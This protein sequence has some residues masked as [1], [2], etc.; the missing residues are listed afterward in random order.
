MNPLDTVFSRRPV[1]LHPN[2]NRDPGPRRHGWARRWLCV[3]LLA[4][5][6]AMAVCTVATIDQKTVVTATVVL[7][8]SEHCEATVPAFPAPFTCDTELIGTRSG[9]SDSYHLYA[10]NMPDTAECITRDNYTYCYADGDPPPSEIAFQCVVEIHRAL[11]DLLPATAQSSCGCATLK[12][13]PHPAK[14]S[15]G[16]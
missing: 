13:A 1:P 12:Q 14:H 15:S 10:T 11:L 7:G 6:S 8:V 3:A 16:G 5:A 2:R 4:P 9:G